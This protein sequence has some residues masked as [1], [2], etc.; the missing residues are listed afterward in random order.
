MVSLETLA[1]N[2]RRV[3]ETFRRIG[4]P[5]GEDEYHVIHE[6]MDESG[7]GLGF[8]YKFTHWQHLDPNF[9]S[10]LGGVLYSP[11]LHEIINGLVEKYVFKTMN[12]IIEP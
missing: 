11:E 5:I 7:T 3:L 1:E 2:E 12:K 8:N 4:K 9:R 6:I 10:A